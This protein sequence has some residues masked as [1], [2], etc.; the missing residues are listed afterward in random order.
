MT[1]LEIDIDQLAAAIVAAMPGSAALPRYL[2]LQ[3]VA[4]SLDCSAEH[5]RSLIEAGHMEAVDIADG[6]KKQLRVPQASLQRFMETR[7][8]R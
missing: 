8:K 2:A 1:L 4:D 7:K 3:A 5:V 6:G